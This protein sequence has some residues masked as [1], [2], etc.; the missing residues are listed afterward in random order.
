MTGVAELQSS[1]QYTDRKDIW[2][3]LVVKNLTG[4]LLEMPWLCVKYQFYQEI[5][6]RHENINIYP[7]WLQLA[8]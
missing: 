7:I 6:K 2:S 3:E 5:S 1:R 4:Q 8:R